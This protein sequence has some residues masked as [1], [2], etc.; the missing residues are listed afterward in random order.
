M[1]QFPCAVC[2]QRK[3]LGRLHAWL[4]NRPVCSPAC[5][6]RVSGLTVVDDEAQCAEQAT[7]ALDACRPALEQAITAAQNAAFAHEQADELA[8]GVRLPGG[9]VSAIALTTRLAR[10]EQLK[11]E[12]EEATQTLTAQLF[13]LSQRLV[14][15]VCY[16][17]GLHALGHPVLPALRPLAHEFSVLSE[18]PDLVDP[19]VRVAELVRLYEL[20]AG[21]RGQIAALAQSW[22]AQTARDSLPQ[23]QV[24]PAART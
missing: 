22:A 2:G 15:F 12:A 19:K 13:E 20:L 3:R 16:A 10:S 11:R 18:A 8:R 7:V 4:A 6:A 21:L 1:F 14:P 9:M 23:A 24:E 17:M 5:Q